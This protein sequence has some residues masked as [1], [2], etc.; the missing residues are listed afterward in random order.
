MRRTHPLAGNELEGRLSMPSR[1]ITPKWG[2]KRRVP[3]RLRPSQAFEDIPS[4]G[5]HASEASEMGS[6]YG[7]PSASGV[8]A[9]ARLI[10]MSLCRTSRH[11]KGC[12]VR[13]I[14]S[15]SIIDAHH[16]IAW[17]LIRPSAAHVSTFT[18]QR[19]ATLRRMRTVSH[20]APRAAQAWPGAIHQ[21]PYSALRGAPVNSAASLAAVDGGRC[22]LSF[23]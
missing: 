11:A 3:E 5:P 21:L 19:S 23:A 22:S 13:T 16:D 8:S 7:H 17:P 15:G 6:H 4:T 18:R 1:T 10:S 9:R 20:F 14:I 12:W 2:M